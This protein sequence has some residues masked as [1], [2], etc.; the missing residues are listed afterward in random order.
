MLDMPQS[1]VI[2]SCR[3]LWK[4]F[5]ARPEFYFDTAGYAIDTD[6]LCARMRREGHIPAVVDASFDVHR[7]EIFVIMGLSGSGK[8][9]LVRCL[10]RLVDAQ[11]GTIA[12]E[13]SDLRTASGDA[14]I[15]IRRKKMGM[16]FQS[17]GLLPHLT[18][19]ENVAFPL[20]LQGIDR[21]AREARAQE[22]LELVE[23]GNRAA[24]F[25]AELS[26][27]QQQRIGIA[28]SLAPDPELWFLDEPFSA[29]DP[30]IRRQMQ[31]EFLRLQR[32]LQ[33]TIVFIS[34][35]I[36]EACRLADRIALMRGGKI[37]QIGTPAEILLSPADDYV[38]SFTADVALCRAI[39][40]GDLAVPGEGQGDTPAFAASTPIEAVLPAIAKGARCFSIKDKP[41]LCLKA[42]A[43]VTILEREA[44]RTEAN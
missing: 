12:F 18:A 14:L 9:T 41:G 5:G 1:Q 35:D 29:L 37:I 33:K 15:E 42:D 30:L 31:D 2:L 20:K 39:R 21:A 6:A 38:A 19:L 7:G 8:S 17:F 22:M 4:V 23:L 16:V 36:M 27:G 24:A 25:P 13:G 40:V 3:S 43:V 10:S 34:H 44:S 32:Q 28:R 26:G 11:Y